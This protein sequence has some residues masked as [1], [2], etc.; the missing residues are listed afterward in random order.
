MSQA[1]HPANAP[2]TVLPA[3]DAGESGFAPLLAEPFARTWQTPAKAM[4]GAQA[5]RERLIARLAASRAGEAEMVTVRRRRLARERLGDGVH[6]QT[7]YVAQTG[8]PLRP[9]EP[10]R[11][12]L[13]E[14][15]AGAHLTPEMLGSPAA[16]DECHREWLVMS[17]SAQCGDEWL[18]LRDYHVTPA[19]HSTP[20]WRSAE[21][22]LLFVRE[23]D[24]T[25]AAADQPFSVRD[26]D[27][28][29]PDFAPGIQRRVLWQRDGQAAM[30]YFVQPGV[31]IAHHA[32]EHD[33]ECLMLQGDLFLDDLVLRPGDYQVAP[34]GT[35]HRSTETD[36]GVVLYVH[37]DL[38][39]RFVA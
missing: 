8:R 36:T 10:L 14:L 21:G 11:T 20:T 23:S 16:F 35:D 22:A 37:G 27:A 1:N 17:G 39:L 9:G 6:A 3:P 15:S 32:H 29:W 34:V 30:L 33:E 28:G 13:I 18:S 19:G 26:A 25:A 2:L 5:V 7:L 31:H 24:L 38:D 12:R 4:A